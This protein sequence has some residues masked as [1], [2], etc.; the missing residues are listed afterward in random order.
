MNLYMR[1]L[2]YN[3]IKFSFLTYDEIEK[4]RAKYGLNFHFLLKIVNF[5]LFLIYK[6]NQ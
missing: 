2:E 3:M 1:H 6:S 4:F 5:S